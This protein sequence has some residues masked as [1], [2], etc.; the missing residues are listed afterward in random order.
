MKEFRI[1][2][3]ANMMGVSIA[4]L[5]YYEQEGLL[6]KIKRLPNGHRRYREQDIAWIEF[7]LCLRDGGMSMASLRHYV[8]L[9]RQASTEEARVAILEAH[10]NAML[11]RVNDLQTQIKRIDDK[12]AWYHERIQ[13]AS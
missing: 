10:R 13:G 3:V 11:R 6:G 7:V 9:C 12:V 1:T 8:G 5:R 4:T 2:E